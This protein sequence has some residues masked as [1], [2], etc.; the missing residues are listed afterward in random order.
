MRSMQLGVQCFILVVYIHTRH[1]IIC[2]IGALGKLCQ[3]VSY[4]HF[5]YFI[6]LFLL[7]CYMVKVVCCRSVPVFGS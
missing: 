1:F 3:A 2:S 6:Y 4:W 7:L 5:N